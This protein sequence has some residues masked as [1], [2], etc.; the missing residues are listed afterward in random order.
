[1]CYKIHYAAIEYRVDEVTSGGKLKRGHPSSQWVITKC[2]DIKEFKS[3]EYYMSRFKTSIGYKQ[4]KNRRLNLLD[5]K[6]I[7]T[8][9][10][11]LFPIPD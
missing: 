5:F 1:M 10:N 11:S 9:G 4:T 8:V 6:I 3:S 2:S 7:R